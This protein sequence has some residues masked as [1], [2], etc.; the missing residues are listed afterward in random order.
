MTKRA[1]H[2]TVYSK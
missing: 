2:N 1:A